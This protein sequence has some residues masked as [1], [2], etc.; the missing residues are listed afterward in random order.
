M[1]IPFGNLE[2]LRIVSFRKPEM[3]PQHIVGQM[4]ALINPED[5]QKSIRLLIM[6]KR[7]QMSK[8]IKSM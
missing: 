4:E 8:Q 7:E 6:M 2:K 3:Q 5:I 1:P